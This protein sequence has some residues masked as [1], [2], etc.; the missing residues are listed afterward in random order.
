MYLRNFHRLKPDRRQ[1]LPRTITTNRK[2][3]RYMVAISLPRDTIEPSPY[4][5]TVKAIA[6]QAASGATRMTKPTMW[7]MAWEKASSTSTIGL[8]RGPRW[9]RA[10]PNRVENSRICR[11]SLLA[12]APVT[13]AGM[14]LSRK[15]V[16]LPEPLAAVAV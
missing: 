8:P 2:Q 14:M 9:A 15:S 13:L 6:P 12:K 1:M 3:V 7:N 5:P 11:I 16:K 4:L 10:M